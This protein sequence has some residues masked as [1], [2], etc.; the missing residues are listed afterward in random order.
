[1]NEEQALHTSIQVANMVSGII[2]KNQAS[3]IQEI[4]QK[5]E[6]SEGIEKELIKELKGEINELQRRRSEL[7]HLEN[8]GDPLHLLQVRKSHKNVFIHTIPNTCLYS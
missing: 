2:E 1:M 5:R 8:S 3:L 7:Q 4:Q 6:A